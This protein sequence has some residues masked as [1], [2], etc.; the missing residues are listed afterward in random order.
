MRNLARAAATAG[1]TVAIGL[2]AVPAASAAQHEAGKSVTADSASTKATSKSSKAT[3]ASADT[4]AVKEA[5]ASGR[6]VTVNVYYVMHDGRVISEQGPGNNAAN[7]VESHA[8]AVDLQN[9]NE[10]IRTGDI[11][12]EVEGDST[13]SP[14]TFEVEGSEQDTGETS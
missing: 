7:N 10:S 2:V 12:A 6:P 5:V 1:I 14:V 9:Q 4:S 13:N 8:G 11:E 3:S